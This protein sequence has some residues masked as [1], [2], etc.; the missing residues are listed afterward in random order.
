MSKQDWIPGPARPSW[1]HH[2]H[3][4]S[5]NCAQCFRVTPG[6]SCSMSLTHWNPHLWG[7]G[8]KE[9]SLGEGLGQEHRDLVNETSTLLKEIL[10]S[11]HS[12]L[13]GRRSYDH[14]WT[15]KLAYQV[16]NLPVPQPQTFW[17]PELWKIFYG[18]QVTPKCGI[19]LQ[20]PKKTRPDT[21]YKSIS[22]WTFLFL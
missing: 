16:L 18:L 9:W 10:E 11:L 13:H 20:E 14:L 19:L 6:S 17:P 15:T 5:W 22:L 2:Q 7:K 12:F 4:P 3:F 8:A 21:N 1:V